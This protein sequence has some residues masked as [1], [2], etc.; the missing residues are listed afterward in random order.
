MHALSA[1]GKV[2]T[3]VCAMLADRGKVMNSRSHR[4]P[5]SRG[6]TL[7]GANYGQINLG[8]P[9]RTALLAIHHCRLDVN[10]AIARLGT[11]SSGHR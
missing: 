6:F 3:S 2:V 11:A 1:A 5:K 9:D 7:E 10:K 8:Q 4:R